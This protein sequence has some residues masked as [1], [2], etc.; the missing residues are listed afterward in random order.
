MITRI[1]VTFSIERFNF[2]D[3]ELALVVCAAYVTGQGR[4]RPAVG[5]PWSIGS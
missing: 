4:I 1:F 5:L 3:Q 2:V